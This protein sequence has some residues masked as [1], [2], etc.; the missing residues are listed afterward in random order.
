ML[1]VIVC[2]LVF[3]LKNNSEVD[4]K[5]HVQF[6]EVHNDSIKGLEKK[7][8][9]KK[10]IV[11]PLGPPLPSCF[12]LLFSRTFGRLHLHRQKNRRTSHYLIVMFLYSGI[13]IYIYI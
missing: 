13:Y 3:F 8:L 12:L 10:G 4:Y 6:C 7:N 2:H 11:Y 5:I 9:Q 1:V